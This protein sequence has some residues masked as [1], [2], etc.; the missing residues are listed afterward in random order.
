MKEKTGLRIT[1]IDMSGK[2]LGDSDNDSSMMNNHAGRLVCQ[3]Q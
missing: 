1:V 2:V 3:V